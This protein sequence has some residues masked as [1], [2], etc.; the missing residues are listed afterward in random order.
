MSSSGKGKG[1]G[2][3]RM[4]GKGKGGSSGKG[5]GKGVIYGAPLDHDVMRII[6]HSRILTTHAFFFG[7][8]VSHSCSPFT[9]TFPPTGKPT[10]IPTSIPTSIP[11]AAPQTRGPTR[12]PTTTR[13][14]FAPTPLA[15]QTQFRDICVPDENGVYGEQ[16]GTLELVEFAYALETLPGTSTAIVE[17]TIDDLEGEIAA[18]VVRRLA[19]DCANRRELQ[20]QVQVAA[21]VEGNEDTTAV[22]PFVQEVGQRN[23]HASVHR[24]LA[25]RL[26]GLSPKPDDRRLTDRGCPSVSDPANRCDMVRASL[27]IWTVDDGERRHQRRQLQ[28]EISVADQVKEAIQDA[29][30]EGEFNDSNENVVAVTWVEIDDIPPATEAPTQAP[31]DDDRFELLHLI[32]VIVGSAL[33]LCCGLM[34]TCYLYLR[35]ERVNP[36]EGGNSEQQSLKTDDRLPGSGPPSSVRVSSGDQRNL[37]RPGSRTEQDSMYAEPPGTSYQDNV[38]PPRNRLGNFEVQDAEDLSENSRGSRNSRGSGNNRQVAPSRPSQISQRQNSRDSQ[39]GR[40]S[41]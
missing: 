17:Q 33:W 10:M 20:F 30:A 8:S 29:M 34:I 41:V 15:T 16:T 32:L 22:A 7:I 38:P 6:F 40:M 3:I 9:E 35:R 13:P 36:D 21:D 1:K 5:K 11:T 37:A 18:S 19:P 39:E 31:D 28:E 23:K 4:M 14:T 25:Q 27:T 2:S 12:R 26:V 24:R